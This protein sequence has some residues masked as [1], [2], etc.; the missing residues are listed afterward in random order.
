MDGVKGR[1]RWLLLSLIAVLFIAAAGFYKLYFSSTDAAIRHAEAFLFRRMTVAQL[2]EHGSFRFFYTTNRV[3]GSTAGG[4]DER[5]GTD[6]E[7][8]LKFGFFDAEIQPSLGLGMLINP[9]QWLQNEE[10]QLKDVRSIA[11]QEFVQQLREQVEK[12]PHRALLIVVHGFR[13]AYE[14]ALRKTAFLGHVLDIN[15]PML[16]FDWP[17]NQGSSLSGYRRARDVATASGAELAQTLELVINEVH[18]QRLWVIANSM[19]AQVVAHAFSKLYQQPEFSDSEPE[20]EH[21]ILTAPDIGQEEFDRRFR[22]EIL[23]LAEHLTVYVSSNDRALLISRLVNREA[24]RGESTL[25]PDQFEEA[26]RV[27]DLMQPGDRRVSLIDVTPVNRTRNFHNFSLETP[28]YFDDLF[29][30][31]SNETT[32][33]SRLLYQIETPDGRVYSVLTRGR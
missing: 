1:T 30:R 15:A 9:T 16:L 13:E 4:I 8:A 26:V 2:A 31:L 25:S 23:A 17:G 14:S 11:R 22:D 6:R 27:A 29:L 20:I 5:F 21:V 19:G 28:E 24:R 12:S 3:P 18:P 10:I 7:T 33:R 32:P